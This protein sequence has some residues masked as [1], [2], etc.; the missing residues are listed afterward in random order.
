V[1]T[2][3]RLGPDG[4][5]VADTV[6]A[7]HDETYMPPEVAKALQE[8]GVKLGPGAEHPEGVSN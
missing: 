6:L 7:K 8:K 1:V 5:F 4:V 2:E 3:G